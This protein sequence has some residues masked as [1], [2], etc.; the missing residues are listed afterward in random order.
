[1]EVIDVK[2]GEGRGLEEEMRRWKRNGR[3]GEEK[4]DG[5]GMEEMEVKGGDR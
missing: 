2:G 4:R 1:M 5:R 3:E